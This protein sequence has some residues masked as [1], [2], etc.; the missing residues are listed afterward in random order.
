MPHD[1]PKSQRFESSRNNYKEKVLDFASKTMLGARSVRQF[2]KIQACPTK[3]RTG[4][5]ESMREALVLVMCVPSST[6]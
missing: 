4:N 3:L 5:R 6:R 2:L 1:V